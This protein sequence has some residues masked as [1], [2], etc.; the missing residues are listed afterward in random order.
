MR[1]IAGAAFLTAIALPFLVLPSEGRAQFVTKGRAVNPR[2]GGFELG[3]AGFVRVD[4]DQDERRR[5]NIGPLLHSAFLT[6][7]AESLQFGV[8]LR[9]GFGGTSGLGI[10]ASGQFAAEAR[11]VFGD[12]DLMP[13]L[14]TGFG[15][16][17][18]NVPGEGGTPVVEP[19]FAIPIG[20]GLDSRLTDT[21]MLGFSL[22]YTLQPTVLSET[23]GPADLAICIVFL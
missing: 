9:I 22:R 20:I 14:L 17:F 2:E 15:F 12:I 10:G 13:F 11:Y 16:T 7:I 4:R 5:T 3:I 23:T 8:A 19:R 6:Q 1:S 18:Q 21:L